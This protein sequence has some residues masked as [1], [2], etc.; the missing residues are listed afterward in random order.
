MIVKFADVII[1]VNNK[2]SYVEEMYKNYVTDEKSI[3]FEV[4]VN[5]EEISAEDDYGYDKG[6]LESLAIYRKIA[7]M[8]PKYNGFLLHGVLMNVDGTGIMLL[9][10]SGVGKTTHTMLWKELLGDKCKIVN[11]DKP[12]VR[13]IDGKIYGYGTP[14]GGKE[15]F[16]LNE[17]VEISHICFIERSRDNVVTECNKP[18]EGLLT[19]IYMSKVSGYLNVLPI[20]SEFIRKVDFHIIGCNMEKEA[21]I[22]AKKAILG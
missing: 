13:I 11:G 21:A 15:G 2:Y 22:V 19:Q 9:A 5:D 10:K 18:L 14:Y 7:E 8:M 20:L 12:I 17:K 3:D 4:S 6:Y 16:N 1:K